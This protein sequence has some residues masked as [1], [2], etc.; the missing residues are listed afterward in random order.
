[1]KMVTKYISDDGI[2]FETKIECERYEANKK[3]AKIEESDAI[4]RYMASLATGMKVMVGKMNRLKSKAR[5]RNTLAVTTQKMVK[6]RK[7][8]KEQLKK[9]NSSVA[10]MFAL[11]SVVDEACRCFMEWD[12]TLR[13]YEWLKMGFRNSLKAL[14]D[15]PKENANG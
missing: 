5:H 14:R 6:S 2:T 7:M 1:M 11:K 13:E 3:K 12:D 8:F 10:S 9:S 4:E 15:M